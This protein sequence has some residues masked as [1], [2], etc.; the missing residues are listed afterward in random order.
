MASLNAAESRFD[1]FI[2][3]DK[4]LRYQ[5][6]LAKRDLAILELPTNQ[7]PVIEALIP[8]ID[9]ALDNIRAGN[10]VAIPFPS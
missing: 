10:F 5:Q 6:N 9:A 1:V 2:T 7:V 4:N 3:T 8:I